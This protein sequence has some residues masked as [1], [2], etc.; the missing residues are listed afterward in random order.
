MTDP[1]ILDLER[2]FRYSGLLD[3]LRDSAK[4]LV[5]RGT[6]D[7]STLAAMATQFNDLAVRLTGVVREDIRDEYD[8]LIGNLDP[9]RATLADIYVRT[10]ALARWIDMIHQ[11][12]QFLL[13]QEVAVANAKEV[14]GKVASVLARDCETDLAVPTARLE[15]G[16]Y[17]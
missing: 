10:A 13:S 6:P 1:L 5:R 12:P 9:E 15:A 3:Q 11:T 17:L 14:K 16:N 7:A 4:Y 8:S 2:L